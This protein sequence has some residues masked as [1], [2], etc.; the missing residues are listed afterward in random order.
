MGKK[1]DGLSIFPA[2]TVSGGTVGF[3]VW[4]NPD[5]LQ[6]PAFFATPGLNKQNFS[7]DPG[8]RTNPFSALQK[9]IDDNIK[10]R[11]TQAAAPKEVLDYDDEDEEREPSKSPRERAR[12][13]AKVEKD[14]SNTSKLQ[15]ELDHIEKLLD[16]DYQL[17]EAAQKRK[18]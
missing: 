14:L 3:E 16:G 7:V 13:M 12:L 4:A 6:T 10:R 9:G 15:N 11:Q 1:R 2:R 5:E 18:R 8:A 17:K